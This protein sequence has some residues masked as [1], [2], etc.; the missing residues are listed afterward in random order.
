LG[1]E[2]EHKDWAK[3]GIWSIKWILKRQSYS[4]Y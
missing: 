3:W 2:K 1:I 4:L